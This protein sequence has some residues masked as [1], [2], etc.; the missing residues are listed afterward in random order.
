M[1][2]C[3]LGSLQPHSA[4][5]ERS[6]LQMSVVFGIRRR[7]CAAIG[8]AVSPSHG[9]D[10]ADVETTEKPRVALLGVIRTDGLC[11][12]AL[13]VNVAE[14]SLEDSTSG[15]VQFLLLTLREELLP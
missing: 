4:G 5:G 14:M 11:Y 12:A 1:S 8:Q 9:I 7:S 2:V 13:P 3:G 6:R 15:D 10:P